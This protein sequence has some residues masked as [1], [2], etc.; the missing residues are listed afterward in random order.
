MRSPPAIRRW[1][2]SPNRRSIVGLIARATQPRK[3]STDGRSGSAGG[4]GSK[5]NFET[6]PP[7]RR[8]ESKYL[9]S[10]GSELSGSMASPE[11]KDRLA[12]PHPTRPVELA[13]REK[14]RDGGRPPDR[15]R[16][17]HVQRYEPDMRL[18]SQ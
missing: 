3:S 1:V 15:A 13:A 4:G 10:G 7:A 16:A 9:Q 8:H 11:H 18:I 6:S 2:S 17:A 12:G 14:T 5:V